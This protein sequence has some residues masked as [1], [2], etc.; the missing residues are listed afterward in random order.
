MRHSAPRRVLVPDREL[1]HQAVVGQDARVVRDHQPGPARGHVLDA[2]GLHAPPHR[3][4]E[5][6]ER[7]SRLGETR[8]G[9][10]LVRLLGVPG[11]VERALQPAEARPV[12][13]RPRPSSRR[14]RAPPGGCPRARLTARRPQLALELVDPL[15]ERARRGLR[16]RPRRPPARRGRSGPPL[17][18]RSCAEP[19]SRRPRTPRAPRPPAGAPRDSGSARNASSASRLE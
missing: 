2:R 6:E 14:A 5:L 16:L 13:R 15:L 8:V 10:E 9:A 3:V 17:P 4:E 12:E 18:S 19:R 1:H 7:P 11:E